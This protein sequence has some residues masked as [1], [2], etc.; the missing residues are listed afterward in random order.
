MMVPEKVKLGGEVHLKIY[1][2][3]SSAV[4]GEEKVCGPRWAFKMPKALFSIKIHSKL[5][6]LVH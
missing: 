3:V 2:V 1:H 5:S 6:F 4:I